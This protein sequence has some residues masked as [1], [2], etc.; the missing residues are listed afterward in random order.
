M[1][2]LGYVAGVLSLLAGF[3][4]T[5]VGIVQRDLAFITVG[6]GLLGAPGFT[7]AVQRDNKE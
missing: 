6:A 4:A 3:G 1:P 2:H 7:Q 5:V